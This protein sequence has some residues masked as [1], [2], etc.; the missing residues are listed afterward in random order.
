LAERPKP[1]ECAPLPKGGQERAEELGLSRKEASMF[2]EYS[3]SLTDNAKELRKNMT[4]EERRLWYDF[5]RG[6]PVRFLRQ[7]VVDNYILDFYCSDAR[8]CVEIDG[9]QHESAGN[10][11]HDAIRSGELGQLGI[12][13]IRF[14]N[15]EIQYR[16]DEVCKR[17][18]QKVN[19]LMN[20][21][22]TP[23]YNSQ[24]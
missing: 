18:R 5:L 19:E 13:V 22:R 10:R 6:Y 20:K 14:T 16:F 23:T 1:A 9:N 3:H 7:K 2:F 8:L 17:I 24:S 15:D 21:D 12:I 11:E 4:P